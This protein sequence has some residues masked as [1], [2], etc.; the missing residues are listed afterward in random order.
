VYSNM[1]AY[2]AV[3]ILRVRDFGRGFGSSYITHS[4]G[5]VSEVKANVIAI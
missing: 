2:L 4:L 5:S 3:P 1:L